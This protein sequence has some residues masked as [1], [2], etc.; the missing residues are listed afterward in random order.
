MTRFVATT[1]LIS[2]AASAGFAL[3]AGACPRQGA[4]GTEKREPRTGR[5]AIVGLVDVNNDG[6]SDLEK[7]RRIIKVNGGEIDA[8]LGMDGKLTGELR[9]DTDYIILGELP[10][11]TTITPGV[12]KQFDAFLRRASEL[13]IPVVALTELLQRGTKRGREPNAHSGF[14]PRRPLQQPY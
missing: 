7:M 10:E 1:I 14:R 6:K 2:A 4:Y 8:E 13:G 5:Y 12:A 3:H 11:E 9:P